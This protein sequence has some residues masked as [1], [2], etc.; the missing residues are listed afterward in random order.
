MMIQQ[1]VISSAEAEALTLRALAVSVSQH[2]L[3]PGVVEDSQG[4]TYY[5]RRQCCRTYLSNLIS[6]ACDAI[7]LSLPPVPYGYSGR[8]D[9]LKHP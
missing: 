7:T 4:P 3:L 5:F 9:R 2:L 6:L 1:S 8:P